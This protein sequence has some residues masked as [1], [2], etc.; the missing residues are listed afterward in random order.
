MRFSTL[1]GAKNFEFFQIYGMSTR[2]RVSRGQFFAILCGRLLWTAPNH[3]LWLL[4]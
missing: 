1:F 4:Y 3:I 2:T